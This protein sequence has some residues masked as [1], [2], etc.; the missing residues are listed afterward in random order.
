MNLQP[1]ID[2]ILAHFAGLT[3]ALQYYKKFNDYG[4]DFALILFYIL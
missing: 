2:H 1:K 3:V 4:S